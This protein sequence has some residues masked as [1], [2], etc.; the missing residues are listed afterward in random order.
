MFSIDKPSEF[1]LDVDLAKAVG[2]KSGV[3]TGKAK[4]KVKKDI[5]LRPK[6]VEIDPD[7]YGERSEKERVEAVRAKFTKNEDLKQILMATRDAKLMQYH[8]GAPAEPDH[9]LMAVRRELI[10]STKA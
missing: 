7:F 3:P 5:L 1:S 2:S 9:V 8:R 10:Q 4:T 6:T